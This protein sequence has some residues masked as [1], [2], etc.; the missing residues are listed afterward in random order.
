[1]ICSECAREADDVKSTPGSTHAGY[2]YTT[3]LG[4]PVGHDACDE[5]DC[6]HKPVGTSEGE[7]HG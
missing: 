2:R 1:M 3:T 6:Q 4:R 5:C 7:P